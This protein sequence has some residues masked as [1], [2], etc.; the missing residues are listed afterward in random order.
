MCQ[1]MAVKVVDI[2][3]RNTQR[4]SQSLSERHADKQG[5]QQTWTARKSNRAQ[6]FAFDSSLLQSRINNRNDVLL[7][8]TTGE[9]WD[10]ATIS[11]VNSLT[12][13]HIREQNS[14]AKD[15][16][17]SIVATALYT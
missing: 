7:M 14:I 16:R 4:S 8:S 1:D 6:L 2:Y 13:R 12:G 9:F 17:R 5:A 15:C 3:H 10:H 11:L